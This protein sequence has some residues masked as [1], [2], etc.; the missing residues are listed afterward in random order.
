MSY[1]FIYMKTF[2]ATGGKNWHQLNSMHI[3]LPSLY[4]A[5]LCSRSHGLSELLTVL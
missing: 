2:Y 1:H 5:A 4:E 3:P